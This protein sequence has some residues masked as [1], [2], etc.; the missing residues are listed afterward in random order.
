MAEFQYQ[1]IFEHSE[2]TTEYR[3]LTSGYVS[4]TEFEGREILK[5]E[6]AALTLIA[7]EAMDDVAHLLRTSHL[8]Q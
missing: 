6:P 3:S 5:I 2:D 8:K 1:E 7:R 4:T